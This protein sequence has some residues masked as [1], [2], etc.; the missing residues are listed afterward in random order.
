MINYIARFL[1]RARL[2]PKRPSSEDN[3]IAISSDARV[4]LGQD[5]AVFLHARSGIVFTSNHIGAQIWQGLLN[6]DG[7]E[8]IAASI[9][10]RAGVRHDQV[11]RDTAEFVAELETQGFLSRR[12][13]C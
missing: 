13:G 2:T 8:T 10:Q 11:R 1:N 12:I 4:S 6:S 7:V 3:P 9:S 5:G